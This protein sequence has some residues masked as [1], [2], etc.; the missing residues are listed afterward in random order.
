MGRRRFIIIIGAI[1]CLILLHYSWIICAEMKGKGLIGYWRFDEGKG[2]SVKDSSGQENNGMINGDAKWVKD[3]FGFALQFNGTDNYVDFGNDS[4]LDIEDA[5]TFEAWFKVNDT[6]KI[7]P[8]AFRLAGHSLYPRL[9]VQA[10]KKLHWQYKLDT[11][12]KS[13]LSPAIIET[14]KWYYVVGVIDSGKGGKLYLNGKL[15]GSNPDV[16]SIDKGTSNRLIGV[17]TNLKESLGA[18][19]FDGIIDEAKI[20]NRALDAAEIKEK[21]EKSAGFYIEGVAYDSSAGMDTDKDGIVDSVEKLIWSDVNKKEELVQVFEDPKGDAQ[22]EGPDITGIFFGNAGGNRYVWR[23]DFLKDFVPANTRI[24]LYLDADND[25]NTGRQDK[26]FAKGVDLMFVLEDTRPSLAIHNHSIEIGSDPRFAIH[27]NKVYFSLDVSLN[28]EEGKAVYSIMAL[29]QSIDHAKTFDNFSLTPVSGPGESK[30]PKPLPEIKDLK[31]LQPSAFPMPDGRTEICWITDKKTLPIATVEYVEEERFDFRIEEFKEGNESLRNHRVFIAGLKPGKKYNVRICYGVPLANFSFKGGFI[32]MQ[33]N[34]SE[35][36]IEITVKEPTQNSRT[37]WPVTSGIPF[38]EGKLTNTDNVNLYDETGKICPA[39]FSARSFWPDGSIRWLLVD[40]QTN[41]NP[42]KENKYLLKIEDSGKKEKFEGIKISSLSDGYEIFNGKMKFRISRSRLRLFEDLL[43]DLNEDGNFTSEEQITDKLSSGNAKLVDAQGKTYGFGPADFLEIEEVG[44]LR[45]VIRAKGDFVDEKNMKFMRYDV[46]IFCYYNQPFLRIGFTIGNNIINETITTIQSLSMQISIKSTNLLKASVDTFNEVVMLEKK[47]LNILQDYDN[48]FIFN[49]EGKTISGER[50]PGIAQV[51]ND[52]Y[53]ISGFVKDFWQTYPKGIS[54]TQNGMEF[55][56]LPP[57]PADQYSS[58]IKKDKNLYFSHYFWCSD[59]KY[60]IKRGLEYT[61]DVFI[62]FDRADKKPLPEIASSHFQNPLFAQAPP[63]VYCSSG[64][65]GGLL[66]PKKEGEFELYNEIVKRG[67][68]VIEKNRVEKREYGWMNYGDW[69]GERGINWGNIEY[70]LQNVLA[71]EFARSGDLKYFWRGLE[72]AS[73][74]IDIDTIHYPWLKGAAMRGLV[75]A[76]CPGHTGGFFT[77]DD[78][79]IIA[80]REE[81]GTGWWAIGAIDPKGHIFQRGNL[82]YSFLTGEKRFQEV[83]E[84]VIE[85]QATYLTSDFDFGIEREAGWSL[86]NAISAYE[87]T[88]NPFYLNAA[89]IYVEKILEKQDVAGNG[90]WNLPQDRSEC[91]CPDVAS[92]RGGKAFAAAELLHALS[93]YC[94]ICPTPEVKK[95]ILRGCDWLMEYSW[96]KEKGGFRYKTG[97]PKYAGRGHL[98]CIALLTT[99]PF[100]YAYELSGDEKY[101]NFIRQ[102]I[103]EACKNTLKEIPKLKGKEYAMS[104]QLMPYTLYY[105]KKW[106]WETSCDAVYRIEPARNIY[107]IYPPKGN[108]MVINVLTSSSSIIPVSC[109][110]KFNQKVIRWDVKE[111][112]NLSA[113]IEFSLQDIPEDGVIK[114][115]FD[116]GKETFPVEIKIY[117]EPEKSVKVGKTLGFLGKDGHWTLQALQ[118]CGGKPE[119][120]ADLTRPSFDGFKAIVVASD[121]LADKFFE[122]QFNA[123]YLK[124]VD[125]VYSGGTLVLFQLN[126]DKWAADFLPYYVSLSDLNSEAGDILD[127]GHPL[128]NKPYKVTDI[129]GTVSFDSIML[130]DS[131]WKILAIDKNKCPSVMETIFGKGKIVV[132]EPSFDRYVM[133]KDVKSDDRIKEESQKFIK[134]LLFY[135]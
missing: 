87:V 114:G 63:E 42:D 100:A 115:I 113:E 19:N 11:I 112:V 77:Q 71:V 92:H 94:L 90:G 3:K 33:K 96:N 134:N 20:Y 58:D 75:Y 118:A 29:C 8:I 52:N 127:I 21:Y 1:F 107:H 70:D 17:D 62:R 88:G 67:F 89:H 14:N 119:I 31:V 61:S 25:K 108:K 121:M 39:Q 22:N 64:T 30:N 16:G 44:P 65:F 24:I 15:I 74:N 86:C 104:I 26:E 106:G 55:Q 80:G 68:G 53:S 103:N 128:F 13:V 12:T 28:Q 37:F 93:M 34:S 117:R 91:D 132:V 5:I 47:S 27:K 135:M 82:M 105:L 4:S 60:K 59:G 97:C 110:F 101:R 49:S 81:K 73:H 120:I 45:A 48:H 69:Y 54:I 129:S 83:S 18:G 133:G 6:S 95:S 23:I 98:N 79:L 116:T 111:G 32:P 38:V 46:R 40:F 10:D 99:K 125:F 56:V 50:A 122:E 102:F 43:V 76:H 35:F 78:T 85:Y 126:D 72:A 51:W 130:V 66:V 57:L 123:G 9:F 124:L 2:D 7:R 84:K 131:A 36:K 109:S 41:T